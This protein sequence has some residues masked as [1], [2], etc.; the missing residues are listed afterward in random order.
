MTKKR[1]SIAFRLAL[2]LSLGTAI[3]WLGAVAIAAFVMQQEMNE[4]FDD[5]LKKSAKLILPLAIY[6]QKSTELTDKRPTNY[7]SAN[8]AYTVLDAENKLVLFSDHPAN[9]QMPT[10][11]FTQGFKNLGKRRVYG[12]TDRVTGFSIMVSDDLNDRQELL[13]ES[14]AALIWPLLALIPLIALGI[15]FA[16]RLALRPLERLRKDIAMRGGQNLTPLTNHN[17]PKELAPIA[18]EVADLLS[19]LDAA[20]KAERSFAASSAHELRTPIA[21]ALAQTQRLAIEL[22]NKPGHRRIKEVETSLKHLSDMAEKL[23]QL[24][25]LEAGFAK[26]ENATDLMPVLHLVLD[27]FKAN[28]NI[29][30][31]ISNG[32][33]LKSAIHQDAFFMALRNL[34]QNANIHGSHA[35]KV[36]IIIAKDNVIHVKNSGTIISAEILSKLGEPFVRGGSK[37]DGSGLG[38]SIIRSIMQQVGG[39]IS[40]HSPSIGQADGFEAII[41]LP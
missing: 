19:R 27:E 17:H 4:S 7:L 15:W 1:H 38:L 34:V 14:L 36:E 39:E 13:Y 28:T 16:V 41:K 18:D 5:N 22:A 29:H 26:T 25:R 11:K 20:L 23:L 33:T 8:I 37:A 40:F 6:A 21:G 2:G 9:A 35:G 12:Q 32:V 31:Q 30:L 10:M 3:L 24:S